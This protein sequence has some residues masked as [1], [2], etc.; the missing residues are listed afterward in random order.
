MSAQSG[1][2]MNQGLGEWVRRLDTAGLTVGPVLEK[3]AGRLSVLSELPDLSNDQAE[4]AHGIRLALP[5]LQT[6]LERLPQIR[7]QLLEDKI[8]TLRTLKSLRVPH[9]SWRVCS[10]DEFRHHPDNFYSQIPSSTYYLT[11]FPADRSLPRDKRIAGKDEAETTAFFESVVAGQEGYGR[12][13]LMETAKMQYGFNISVGDGDDSPVLVEIVKGTHSD[14]VGMQQPIVMNLRRDPQ[15]RLFRFTTF[16]PEIHYTDED[17]E[18]GRV[19]PKN[20][21]QRVELTEAEQLSVRCGILLA[22][23]SIPHFTPGALE[24]SS[25]LSS[26]R[27]AIFH[28]GYYEGALL[29]GYQPVFIEYSDQPP[30]QAIF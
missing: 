28:P 20:T 5:E 15:R 17:Y 12:V 1:H 2:K 29:E 14:L 10:T 3:L 22:L 6:T 25:N 11:V 27:D 21:R 18:K 24:Y 9:F 7:E 26:L 4:E 23:E 13:L 30:F 19:P 16:K 8:A